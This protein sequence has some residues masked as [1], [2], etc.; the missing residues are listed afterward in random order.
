[1]TK[2]IKQVIH[3]AILHAINEMGMEEFKKCSFFGSNCK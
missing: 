2:D 3:A 1:M